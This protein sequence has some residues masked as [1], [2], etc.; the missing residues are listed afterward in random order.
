MV[1]RRMMGPSL[2]TGAVLDA[3]LSG[4]S[5]MVVVWVSA[6]TVTLVCD[7]KRAGVHPEPAPTWQKRFYDFGVRTNGGQRR[8][9]SRSCATSIATR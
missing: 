6:M 5:H 8:S 1:L 2:E 4:N 3:A 9:K 7:E